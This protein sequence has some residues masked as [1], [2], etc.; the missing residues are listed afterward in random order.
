[1]LSAAC[2]SCAPNLH[3]RL[4]PAAASFPRLEPPQHDSRRSHLHHVQRNA[5]QGVAA[6]AL[7]GERA[8]GEAAA[9]E[10]REDVGIGAAPVGQSHVSE[11]GFTLKSGQRCA[12]VGL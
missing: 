1:V 3:G 10:R 7:R 5:P 6:A 4:L 9:K 11:P 2:Q 12:A 8:R